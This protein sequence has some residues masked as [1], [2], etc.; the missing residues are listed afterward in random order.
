[1]LGYSSVVPTLSLPLGEILHRSD[2]QTHSHSLS[3]Y[4][5]LSL[6][7]SSEIL[8]MVGQA[9]LDMATEVAHYEIMLSNDVIVPLT[10][11]LEV[12]YN[13]IES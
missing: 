3:L 12:L 4:L 10:A 7:L 5:S 2:K 1:M 6:C 8:E 11:M 13:I 9:E